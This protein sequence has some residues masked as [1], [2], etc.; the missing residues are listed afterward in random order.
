MECLNNEAEEIKFFNIK[1]LPDN[2]SP[3]DKPVIQEYIRRI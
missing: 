3:P 1:D 2:I